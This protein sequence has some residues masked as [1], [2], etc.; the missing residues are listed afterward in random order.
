MSG[1]MME[2]VLAHDSVT[3][4]GGAERTLETLLSLCRG[5]LFPGEEDFGIAP[6]EAQACGRPIVA[7]AAGAALETVIDGTKGVLFE[8]QTV[9]SLLAALHRLERLPLETQRIREHAVQFDET[10]FE[11]KVRAFVAQVAAAGP[12]PHESWS[13]I[14]QESKPSSERI[15]SQKEKG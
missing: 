6:L 3:A 7:F 12:P 14:S 2:T 1:N 9:K 8:R 4:Y 10:E 15:E 5:L 13:R 11:R